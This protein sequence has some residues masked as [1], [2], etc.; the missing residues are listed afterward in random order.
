MNILSRSSNVCYLQCSSENVYRTLYARLYDHIEIKLEQW[1]T[2][3]LRS[4][5]TCDGHESNE[6][7]A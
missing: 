7:S 6:Q 3:V 1:Y 5:D 2:C 4:N